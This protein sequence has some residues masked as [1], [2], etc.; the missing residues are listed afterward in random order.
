[1]CRRKSCMEKGQ[2]RANYDRLVWRMIVAGQS[3]RCGG[4]EQERSQ[5]LFKNWTVN[6]Y[7]TRRA[8]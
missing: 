7:E 6:V 1:L 4:F 8:R 5:R 3:R 2:D